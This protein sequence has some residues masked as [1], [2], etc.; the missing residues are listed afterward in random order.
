VIVYDLLD[1][2]DAP[3]ASNKVFLENHDIRETAK[4]VVEQSSFFTLPLKI[5]AFTMS[6]NTVMN[7][8][9]RVCGAETL[10]LADSAVKHFVQGIDPTATG[11]AQYYSINEATFAQWFVL[12][13]S[14]DP[15]TVDKY[16]IMEE[17]LA[18]EQPSDPG[19]KI[20]LA[21]TLGSHTLKFNKVTA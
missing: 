3:L 21:G 18:A 14:N 11:N 8:S 20:T 16:V 12:G 1:N 10:T 4:L 5:R 7:L 2:Q 19:N 13:P 17:T 6:K 9:V 15:C